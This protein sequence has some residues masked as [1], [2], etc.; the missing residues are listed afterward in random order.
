MAKRIIFGLMMIVALTALLVL[1][2]YLSTHILPTRFQGIGF[3]LLVIVI[4]IVA[5]TE[6]SRLAQAKQIKLDLWLIIPVLMLLV[7]Q[8]FWSGKSAAAPVLAGILLISMLIMALLAGITRGTENIMN[9]LGMGAF[10][11]IY[12]G[13]GGWFLMSLRLLGQTDSSIWGQLGKV[14]L[15]LTCVKSCDIGAYFTGK[16]IGRHKWIPS[17][18]PGKTWEGLSGGI[19]L[20]VIVASLFAYW[21]DIIEYSRAVL[22]GLAIAVSG[23]LGDLLES[24]LKRD[25]QS[26]DSGALV[27]EFGGMLDLLDSPLLAAPVAYFLFT[28]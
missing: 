22:F 27:P 25:A 1:D 26:K 13:L 3:A 4:L 10:T 7:T 6:I 19:I 15:F 20:A 28:I 16:L 17:I 14:V 23:Q 24:M 8:P 21:F 11:L 9:L 18:S 12:L 2:G 5:L